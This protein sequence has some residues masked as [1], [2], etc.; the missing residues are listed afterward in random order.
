MDPE[1]ALGRSMYLDANMALVAAQTTQINVALVAAWPL[2]T[3]IVSVGLPKPWYQ[4]DLQ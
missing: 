2:D 3:S 1:M 4:H